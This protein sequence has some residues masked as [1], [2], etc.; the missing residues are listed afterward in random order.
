MECSF[1]RG[2]RI[3]VALGVVRGNHNMRMSGREYKVVEST[4][5]RRE[6]HVFL[7]GETAPVVRVY[8]GEEDAELT[9]A[10]PV[11]LPWRELRERVD[12]FFQTWEWSSEPERRARHP[13]LYAI[14]A[15]I[16]SFQRGEINGVD[17]SI[18]YFSACRGI[19][20]DCKSLPAE[21]V[22]ALEHL[23]V[24]LDQTIW[25]TQTYMK[26]EEGGVWYN[27]SESIAPII[28]DT[29]TVIERYL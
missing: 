2:F 28:A 12:R 3:P 4:E 29:L 10:R 11:T 8:L 1:F 9:V 24:E 15:L 21:V 7:E 19:E 25:P 20:I 22:S 5:P 6:L 13:E 18:A 26:G 17:F 27:G 16:D 23:F 14:K